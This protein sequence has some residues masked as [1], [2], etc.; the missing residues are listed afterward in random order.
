MVLVLDQGQI[1]E[2]GKFQGRRSPFLVSY[3]LIS[4]TGKPRDLIHNN[5]SAFYDFCMAQGKEEYATLCERAAI[6]G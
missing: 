1:I 3:I 2:S 6:T 5:Q 4:N